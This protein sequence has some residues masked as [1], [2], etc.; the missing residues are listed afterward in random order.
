MQTLPAELFSNDTRKLKVLNLNRNNLTSV[1]SA[2]LD[3]VDW[4]QLGISYNNPSLHYRYRSDGC[5]MSH[6]LDC[7]LRGVGS[8]K[9]GSTAVG[10]CGSCTFWVDHVMYV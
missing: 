7:S 5:E 10:V 2:L 6:D 4:E 8:G 1:N 9:N 3:S